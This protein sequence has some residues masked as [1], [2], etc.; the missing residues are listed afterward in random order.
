M[1][2]FEWDADM[3]DGEKSVEQPFSDNTQILFEES[4][5]KNGMLFW[6]ASELLEMLGYTEYKPT[7][8]PIQKA[9]QIFSTLN[10]DITENIKEVY[11]DIDGKNIKDFKLS[12]FACY[13]VA[14]NADTSKPAVAKLQVYFVAFAEAIQNY[15]RDQNDIERVSLRTEISEHEK[16]LASVA[17]MSGVQKY[18]LFQN[19]GY[20][21]LYN[22]STN[23]IR[24][25][26]G[27]PEKKPL[28][29][30]MGAEEL[31]A[32][33]FRITQTSAKIKRENIK[34]QFALEQAAEDVGRQVRN[35]I[36]EIGGA[37]PE[38]LPA[39]EN[40]NKIKTDLK[41]TSREFAK[42]DKKRLEK[43]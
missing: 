11:R 26:K 14:M 2:Q 37:M 34:G 10:L 30:F 6:W 17:K 18:G 19:K 25:L 27:I 35:A 4:S 42:Q 36:K 8:K 39:E 29:D 23:Q 31:G 24:D 21:G 16:T 12:R 3:N 7:L 38:E 20:L 40:I 41:K 13:L 28:I 33:I 32:N 5:H 22:M 43:K 9:V 1:S 15:L